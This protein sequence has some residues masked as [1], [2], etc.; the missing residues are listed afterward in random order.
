MIKNSSE[1]CGK[2]NPL[3]FN[4]VKYHRLEDYLEFEC[5]EIIKGKKSYL[6]SIH[7]CI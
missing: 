5:V 7:Y 3:T 2:L 1:N 6:L 4:R